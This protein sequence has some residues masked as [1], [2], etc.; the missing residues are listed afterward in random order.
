MKT[1]KPNPLRINRMVKTF[2]I[3][4]LII[5]SNLAFAQYGYFEQGYGTTNDE[6][7]F[8]IQVN[9]SYQVFMAGSL[10]Q[11]PGN[12]D[13]YI[14]YTDSI[15]DTVWTKTIGGDYNDVGR[16]VWQRNGSSWFVGGYTN[17][18]GGG[19]Y[20]PY[21]IKLESNGN[22]AFDVALGGS[23]DE[24]VF[25][26][27]QAI[28]GTFILVGYS[29]IGGTNKDILV[30]K[31][32]SSNG[33]AIWTKTFGGLGNQEG[34]AL[35][36]KSDGNIVITGTDYSGGINHAFLFELDSTGTQITY[37]T[38][39]QTFSSYA[40]AIAID[41]NGG[42]WLAGYTA[43]GAVTN[44]LI[45]HV[46]SSGVYTNHS[47]FGSTGNEEFTCITRVG[48]TLFMAGSTT[49]YGEGGTDLYFVATDSVGN[50]LFDEYAGGTSN[51][52]ANGLFHRNG[53]VYIV[54]Y[55][56]S[57]GVSESGNLYATRMNVYELADVIASTNDNS[58]LTPI[59]EDCT[60]PR[61]LYVENMFGD[62]SLVNTIGY[63]ICK[64]CASN[65]FTI[66]QSELEDTATYKGI[67]GNTVRETRL[68]NFCLTHG[69][70]QLYFY[71]S[72]YLFW[73]TGISINNNYTVNLTG[74][75]SK[76]LNTYMRERLYMF[77]TNAYKNYYIDY[78]GLA[79]SVFIDSTNNYTI[80]FNASNYNQFANTFNY[81]NY[82]FAGKLKQVVLE[83]EFWNTYSST[84]Q[85]RAAEFQANYL[86]HKNYLKRMLALYKNDWNIRHVD[87]YIGKLYYSDERF[88]SNRDSIEYARALELD[89]IKDTLYNR[90]YLSRFFLVYDLNTRWPFVEDEN[91][92]GDSNTNYV[93]WGRETPYIPWHRDDY[94]YR[95]ML[96]GH[97]PN[98]KQ[99]N[100]YPIFYGMAAC[101]DNRLTRKPATMD[102]N[103]LGF[104]LGIIDPNN[105]SEQRSLARAEQLF[106][107]TFSQNTYYTHTNKG[108]NLKLN[109]FTYF[110][111]QLYDIVG[112]LN[113]SN[114]FTNNFSDNNPS[115]RITQN[116]TFSSNPC[117]F[118]IPENG[119]GQFGVLNP[120]KVERKSPKS[121]VDITAYP[122]P[123]NA[124]LNYEVTTTENNT[125]SNTYTIELIDALGRSCYRGE[126]FNSKGQINTENLPTGFYYLRVV[127]FTPTGSNTTNKIIFIRK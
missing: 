73:N 74:G 42:Y 125:G 115:G 33:N 59:E 47:S 58:S 40:N 113:I 44:A 38:L 109:G 78:V 118:N 119:Q 14:V 43:N 86:N 105:T 16:S 80:Y 91:H 23:D 36:T 4:L 49:S 68:L 30:I 6:E 66:N 85:N 37:Q 72:A 103:N 51:D 28:D 69:F 41:K 25:D 99:T 88:M 77:L 56:S 55:N 67:I 8:D 39:N 2:L 117:W 126:S 110:T 15:G 62:S 100:V 116:D 98:N 101:L 13:V 112:A 64:W 5:S 124:E 54:G 76:N 31:V 29:N 94:S 46:N 82:S 34:R 87:D 57:F 19:G 3:S 71:H 7:G 52:Y 127:V 63:R 9:A 95:T 75:G 122:N 11:G 121:L 89:L 45:A 10:T 84:T 102:D 107:T 65:D 48:N 70:N 60:M 22:P 114:N 18:K 17:S 83:D 123:T 26:I 108:P 120:G 32:D 96:F 61:V 90:K 104:W 20:D 81:Y 79:G 24:Y 12:K 27:A 106:T 92:C 35:I 53:L 97:R 1:T 21:F 111:Y 50:F 93:I